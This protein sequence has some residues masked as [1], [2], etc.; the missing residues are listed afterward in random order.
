MMLFVMF[1]GYALEATASSW[2]KHQADLAP[3]KRGVGDY[4]AEG[5]VWL[6]APLQGAIR[7][8]D[9]EV[10]ELCDRVEEVAILTGWHP[11][12]IYSELHSRFG[13]AVHP[14]RLE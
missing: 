11:D 5:Y 13:V 3:E 8:T 6:K 12:T 14:K 2:A 7:L 9:T 1:F 4:G 10:E